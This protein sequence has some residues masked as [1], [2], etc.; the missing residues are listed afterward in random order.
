MAG[1]NQIT[2]LIKISI[3]KATNGK[4][5]CSIV[6]VHVGIA[7]ADGEVEGEGA[8]NRTAPIVAEGPNTA[9]ITI[10]FAVKARH[11]QF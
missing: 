10:A 3:L 11:G 2:S 4:S 8:I 1:Y 5:D 7:T 9:E 6:E